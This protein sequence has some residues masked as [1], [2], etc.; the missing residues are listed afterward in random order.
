MSDHPAEVRREVIAELV[1][2][3]EQ[4][5]AARAELHLTAVKYGRDDMAQRA[6]SYQNAWLEVARVLRFGEV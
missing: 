2:R 5:A 6:R 4:N 1:A 3:A